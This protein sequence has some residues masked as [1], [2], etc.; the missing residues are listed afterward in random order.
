MHNFDLTLP[1]HSDLAEEIVKSEYVLALVGA[2]E[3]KKEKDLENGILENLKEFLLELGEGFTFVGNQ[4]KLQ[5]QDND[6]YVDLLFFNQKLNCLFAIELKL[7]EFK[8]EYVS[9]IQY[10]LHLLDQYVKQ[11]H[12]NQTVGVILCSI[13]KDYIVK[14]LLEKTNSPIAVAIYRI[15]EKIEKGLAGFLKTEN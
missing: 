15:V 9:K 8:P 12:E 3:Y 6:Y 13:K 10:Y 11:P 5:D 14:P 7:G 2:D 4:Y 1:E